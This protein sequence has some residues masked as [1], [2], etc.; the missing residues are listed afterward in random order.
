MDWK[1]YED[2]IYQ[3]FKDLYPEA[4]ISYD[5]KQVGL[6][7]KVK[8]QIDVLI[9][10][11][12][13]GN[14]FS[15]V[16]DGKYFNKKIDVKGVES[17]IGML[18]DLG[19][20]KGILISKEGFSEGA[21]NRAHFGPSE[22]ELE[23]LNFK[24]LTDFQSNLAIPYAGKHGVHL[25][26]PFGWIIDGVKTPMGCATLYQQGFTL[27]QAMQEMEFIYVEFWDRKK[28]G[29]TLK[30]L[31][32]LQEKNILKIDKSAKITFLKTIKRQDASTAL[33]VAK[34]KNYPT[35][36]Y[37]GFVEFKDFI[38]YCIMFTPENRKRK[39]IRKLENILST[40]T[41]STAHHS[42]KKMEIGEYQRI[43][44]DIK[45]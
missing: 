20:T 36:E 43:E 27:E 32:A 14:R 5:V 26:A 37:A 24:D 28:D 23:I 18:E 42:L 31:L 17:F 38:F 4:E 30:D 3:Y 33:R 6:Y 21:Y 34:V 41:T 25:S 22:I 10:Q 1:K 13:A 35:N 7:S 15:I 45:S 19:A 9:E 11:Y 16:V 8:R 40:V 29:D 2:E 39:N 12:V 44:L